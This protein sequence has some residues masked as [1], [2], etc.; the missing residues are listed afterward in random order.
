MTPSPEPR[1]VCVVAAVLI[2]AVIGV[3]IWFT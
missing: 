2:T 1:W 3:V